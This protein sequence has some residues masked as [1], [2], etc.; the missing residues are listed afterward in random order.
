MKSK[1]VI[2]ALLLLFG[3]GLSYGQKVKQNK[4]NDPCPYAEKQH[5]KGDR[6]HGS[7]IPDLTEEQEEK[8]KSFHLEFGQNVLPVKNEIKEKEANLVSLKTAKNV[9]MAAINSQIEAI[10][11]LKVQL[12]KKHAELEQEIRKILNDEQ[13]LFFDM[14][15]GEKGP[16]FKNK[17]MMKKRHHCRH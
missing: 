1:L 9:D 16:Q 4:D 12:E 10:G 3:T 8:M 7:K 5:C 2:V 13:R 15:L 14:H 17:K 11:M 6:H